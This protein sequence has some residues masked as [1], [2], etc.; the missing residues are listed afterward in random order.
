MSVATASGGS[1][2]RNDRLT[3]GWSHAAVGTCQV[4][5]G[6]GRVAHRQ[7]CGRPIPRPIAA[8]SIPR[9]AGKTTD[10]IDLERAEAEQG[11]LSA[12]TRRGFL[13]GAAVAGVAAGIA[14]CAPVAAPGWTHL[15]ASSGAPK[16]S[17]G[18]AGAG[19]PSPLPSATA[20]ATL[21]PSVSPSGSGAPV[22]Q[23]WTQHDV[24]A[25][26]VVRRYIGNLAPALQGIYGD[27]VFAKLA[28]ILGAADSYPELSQKPAFVQVPQLVLNDIL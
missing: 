12:L 6:P 8:A 23:G 20:A 13:R 16:P 24:D 27:A 17:A 5:C 7:R 15:P 28:D 18:G 19:S 11:R 4:A 22:P 2:R 1:Q 9:M 25:R 14:A 21:T 10:S 26:N 3:G